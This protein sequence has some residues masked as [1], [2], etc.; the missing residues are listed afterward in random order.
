RGCLPLFVGAAVF[1]GAFAAAPRLAAAEE[2]D[3]PRVMGPVDEPVTS[4]AEVP[5]IG[6]ELRAPSTGDSSL[7][8][9][10]GFGTDPRLAGGHASPGVAL[11]ASPTDDPATR[12]LLEGGTAP[13]GTD[14]PV[15]EQ[16]V[17]TGTKDMVALLIQ[18]GADL[19]ALS[20]EGQPLLVLAVA[21]GRPD[22]TTA[23]LDAGADVDTPVV[24]PASDEFLALVPGRYARF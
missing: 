11:A 23:L 20:H 5:T 17:R 10:I 19:N 18:H 7:Y 8:H 13:D 4:A 16:A 2:T 6:T 21:L 15:L 1:A 24:A 9:L 22:V 3:T 12:L 14:R